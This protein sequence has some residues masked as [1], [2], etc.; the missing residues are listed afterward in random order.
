MTSP[1]SY[2][3][4]LKALAARVSQTLGVEGCFEATGG[5]AARV[6]T[7]PLH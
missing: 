4:R 7:P 1:F 5:G 6:A 2:E 3:C